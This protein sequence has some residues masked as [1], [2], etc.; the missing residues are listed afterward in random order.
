MNPTL[1]Q[2]EQELGENRTFSKNHLWIVSIPKGPLNPASALETKQG[3]RMG[4]AKCSLCP[5]RESTFSCL[6]VG[7]RMASS[8]PSVSPASGWLQGEHTIRQSLLILQHFKKGRYAQTAQEDCNF[9]L[10]KYL[11]SLGGWH[12]LACSWIHLQAFMCLKMRLGFVAAHKPDACWTLLDPPGSKAKGIS[13]SNL[14]STH[15][16]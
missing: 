8:A 16:I 2:A 6:D 15:K 14:L 1:G 3:Q 4:T 11:A 9:A 5:E 12:S 7:R 10:A 13:D